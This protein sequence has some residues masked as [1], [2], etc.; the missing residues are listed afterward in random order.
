MVD[1]FM[2]RYLIRIG[3]TVKRQVVSNAVLT[4]SREVTVGFKFVRE[5]N[6]DFQL[7]RDN[8]ID[9][10]FLVKHHINSDHNYLGYI[11]KQDISYIAWNVLQTK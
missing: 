1:V 3:K 2:E 10:N 6:V 5:R 8:R 4:G 7:L 9:L 11:Y